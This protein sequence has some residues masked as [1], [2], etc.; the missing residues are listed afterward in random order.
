MIDPICLPF[1]NL[2]YGPFHK[3]TR[4]LRPRDFRIVPLP[5]RQLNSPSKAVSLTLNRKT[6]QRQLM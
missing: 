6:Y 5:P 1:S 3:R 4:E 2:F